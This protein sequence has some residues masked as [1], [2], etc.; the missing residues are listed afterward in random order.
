MLNLDKQMAAINDAMDG[1]AETE[2]RK[3]L[4]GEIAIASTAPEVCKRLQVVFMEFEKRLRDEEEIGIVLA[5]FGV[6]HELN[7]RRVAA[8]GPNL[9]FIGGIENG[10]DVT[11][12][13]HVSQLSFLLAPQPKVAPDAPRPKIGFGD[14]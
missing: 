8:L 14:A 3:R 11:L 1:H 9:L 5:S 2:R 6:V 7:V 12:I 13:Q 10:R 4:P